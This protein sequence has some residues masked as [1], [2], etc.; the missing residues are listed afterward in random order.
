MTYLL[1]V[2]SS[3]TDTNFYQTTGFYRNLEEVPAARSHGLIAH[4]RFEG[5]PVTDGDSDGPR[6]LID[7]LLLVVPRLLLITSLDQADIICL[8]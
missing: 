7:E 8:L 2:Y 6:V 1:R 4:D 3:S 5:V